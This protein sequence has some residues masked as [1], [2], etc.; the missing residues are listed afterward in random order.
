MVESQDVYRY[1]VCFNTTQTF[2]G[3]DADALLDTIIVNTV[4]LAHSRYT[5]Y[6]FNS[7]FFL[8]GKYYGCNAK[9]VYLLEGVKDF[10]GEVNFA[11]NIEASV[12]TPASDFG[13]Q[14]KKIAKD[15]L[16]HG[17]FAD[18]LSIDYKVD[19]GDWETGYTVYSDGNTGITRRR[20][21]LPF[22]VRGTDWQFRVNNTEGGDFDLFDLEVS[23]RTVQRSI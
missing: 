22:A 11:A 12:T 4:N 19:E 18:N 1:M 13:Y 21:M 8:N 17:R 7:F 16:V 2:A 6:P 10:V 3:Y 5:N 23:L 14:E 9:G 20:C 15:A